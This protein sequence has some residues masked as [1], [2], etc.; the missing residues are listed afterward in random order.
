M[1]FPSPHRGGGEEM[2]AEP[3]PHLEYTRAIYPYIIIFIHCLTPPGPL[4]T[5]CP[6]MELCT[7]SCNF[8]GGY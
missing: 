3:K 4:K 5:F 6:I 2:A 8:C 7:N 1:S